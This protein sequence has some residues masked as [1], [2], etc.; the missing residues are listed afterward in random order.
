MCCKKI[1][2]AGVLIQQQHGHGG[3]RMHAATFAEDP[4]DDKG[5]RYYND[6][7]DRQ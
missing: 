3:K 7:A 4:F 5:Y 2:K 1:D 6:K